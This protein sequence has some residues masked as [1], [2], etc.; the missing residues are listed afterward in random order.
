[1]TGPSTAILHTFP[2]SVLPVSNNRNDTKR[3]VR[4]LLDDKELRSRRGVTGIRAILSEHTADH[5]VRT[6]LDTLGIG[7]ES[8]ANSVSMV[9]P[10]NR[11]HLVPSIL[12]NA[13]RQ[14]YGNM[15]LVLLL[16]DIEEE[17]LATSDVEDA[18]TQLGIDHLQVIRVPKEWPLGT[19][20]NEGFGAA[21]G[22]Y[23]GRIDDDDYYAPEYLGDQIRAFSYADADIIGKW[24]H[25]AYLAGSDVTVLRFA[26]REYTYRDLILGPTMLMRRSVFDAVRFEPI[27]Q[28]SDTAFLRA[29]GAEGIRVFAT[30]Q[31][32]F[33]YHRDSDPN[34]H[35]YVQPDEH[36]L[37][38]GTV[39]WDG[40][41]F[42][43]VSI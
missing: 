28:G 34:S 32:N 24:S 3:E 41:R 14:R 15:E 8:E 33:L 29:A 16:H 7:Y 12:S 2:R 31:M 4:S 5:R 42:D 37:S 17:A 22:D 19:V 9:A 18:A 13:A 10:T 30:D 23:I 11:A 38:Q 39:M 20:L 26:G 43:R 6:V 1:V 36:F 21:S 40:Q 27:P 35:T 25:Y